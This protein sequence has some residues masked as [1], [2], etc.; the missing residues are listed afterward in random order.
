MESL[1]FQWK[2]CNFAEILER[3]V[4]ELMSGE[5]RPTIDVLC[6]KIGRKKSTIYNLLKSLRSKGLLN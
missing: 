4:I 3:Q 5:D 6:E 1:E 2:V